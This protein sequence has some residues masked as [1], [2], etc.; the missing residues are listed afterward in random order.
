MCSTC[1]HKT[2]ETVLVNGTEKLQSGLG[3]G[4]M[5]IRCDLTGR[6][7]KLGVE[8]NHKDEFTLYSCPTCGRKLR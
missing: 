4:K 1:D 5:I 6:N 2:Y 3:V 7:W 8:D